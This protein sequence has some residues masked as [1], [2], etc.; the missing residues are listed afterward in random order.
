LTK[1]YAYSDRGKNMASKRKNQPATFRIVVDDDMDNPII[2]TDVASF[3]DALGRY[4]ESIFAQMTGPDYYTSQ[5]VL[6]LGEDTFVTYDFYSEQAWIDTVVETQV[7]E[8]LEPYEEIKREDA[9]NREVERRVQARLAEEEE[10]RRAKGEELASIYRIFDNVT[11][12]PVYVGQT[13]RSVEARM[14]EHIKRALTPTSTD[15]LYKFLGQRIEEKNFPTIQVVGQ[16][17]ARSVRTAESTEI[18]RLIQGEVPLFN[19]ESL[20]ASTRARYA[21]GDIQFPIERP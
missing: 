16:V 12:Q 19:I 3:P 5:L 15:L 17:L 1:G 14:Q 20:R 6:L 21:M 2:V 13:K 4:R 18:R 9:L 11:Q 10:L 8:K 7:K